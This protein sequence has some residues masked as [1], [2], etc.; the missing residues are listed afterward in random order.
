M[1]SLVLAKTSLLYQR[2]MESAAPAH[3][4]RVDTVFLVKVHKVFTTKLVDTLGCLSEPPETIYVER[5]GMAEER[6]V[7]DLASLRGQAI[8]YFALVILRSSRGDGVTANGQL[9]VVGAGPGHRDLLTPQA[10]AALRQAEV[11]I[12][13]TGYFAWVPDLIQGKEWL[14][15]PLGQEKEPVPPGGRFG[16][17]APLGRQVALISSGD[18]G[19]YAMASLVLE[20]L[21]SR[22]RRTGAPRLP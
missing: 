6:V 7:R 18:P 10:A 9:F 4:T 13:Y 21:A 20:M 22:C 15:L 17:L 11:V 2:L 1:A 16:I 12:G 3:I 5:V 8:P 19:I 14:A